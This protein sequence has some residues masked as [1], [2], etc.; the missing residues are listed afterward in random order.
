VNNRFMVVIILPITA[1]LAGFA[2]QYLKVKSLEN[3]L[4]AARQDNAR[5][6]LRDLARRVTGIFGRPSGLV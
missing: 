5:A 6:Q 3:D 2:P 1:F 4:S